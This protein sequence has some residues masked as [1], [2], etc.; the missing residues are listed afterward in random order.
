VQAGAAQESVWDYPRPPRLESCSR[1]LRVEFAGELIADTRRAFR[2]LETSHPPV[3]YIPPADIRMQFL[4]PESGSSFC[5]WKGRARYYA[6]TV[7]GRMARRA[8]WSYP[9]PNQAYAAIRDYVAFYPRAM[10]SCTIDGELV[11]PQEGGVLRRVDHARCCRP[12]QG[13]CGHG[14][15]IGLRD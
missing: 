2:V 7:G 13:R 11:R 14:R 3:Y 1:H 6:V 10:D 4:Q 9:E 12:F 8:A 5:E 15:L